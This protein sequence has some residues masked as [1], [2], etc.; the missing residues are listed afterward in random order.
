MKLYRLILASSTALVAHSAFGLV[1][2]IGMVL[3]SIS[4]VSSQQKHKSFAQ[5]CQEK[6][7][8]PTETRHT[9]DVLLEKAG[10]NNCQQAD[11][12]LKNL[13]TLNLSGNRITDVQ[14]LAGLTNLLKLDLS[15]NPIAVKNCPVKPDIC[16]F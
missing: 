15:S 13:N 14:P 6:K 2:T 1:L 3:I 10:T 16:R 8:L 4:F 9:I 11:A 5:W 12:K 7:S